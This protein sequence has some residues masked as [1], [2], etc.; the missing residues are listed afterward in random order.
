[1]DEDFRF[2]YVNPASERIMGYKPEE[3]VGTQLTDHCSTEEINR[4]QKEAEEIM[5]REETW[6]GV[7]FE[8]A[9]RHKDGHDIP[10]EVNSR[11][12]ADDQ[13]RILGY[14]GMT[15]D[16]SERKHAESE[17]NQ[18]QAQFLQAQ[19]MESIGRLAGGVAHDFN[20]MLAIIQG[21]TETILLETD[22]TH[23]AYEKLQEIH[24]AAK[25]S[26]NLTQQLLAFA[27]KQTVTPRVLDL[28][29]TIQGTLSMMERLIGENI[30]LS[31]VPAPDWKRTDGCW[32]GPGPRV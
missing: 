4:I 5:S 22:S 25:R 7:M 6:D 1:M 12:L 8:T 2:T 31:W 15:R 11:A 24:K 16:I 17:K 9:F 18:L 26:A 14:Q 21:Y 10:V 23:P 19:K 27:R 29:D 13:G 28:N 20:N 32:P 3:L 30:N